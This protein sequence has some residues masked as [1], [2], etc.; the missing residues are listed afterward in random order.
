MSHICNSYYYL[1]SDPT[2]QKILGNFKTT[3]DI[4][5]NQMTGISLFKIPRGD[6]KQESQGDITRIIYFHFDFT[7]N[8]TGEEVVE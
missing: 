8:R 3:N 4:H 2:Y 5:G 1:E 6:L 7:R